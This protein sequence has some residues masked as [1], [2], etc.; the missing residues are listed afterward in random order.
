MSDKNNVHRQIHEQPQ[1]RLAT[2]L[3]FGETYIEWN[4]ELTNIKNLPES[5]YEMFL[6]RMRA[7]R[8]AQYVLKEQNEVKP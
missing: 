7:F 3:E 1:V 6:E 4:D 5:E 2:K 8:I